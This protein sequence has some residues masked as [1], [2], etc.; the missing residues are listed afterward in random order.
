[1]FTVTTRARSLYHVHFVWHNTSPDPARDGAG[2]PSITC[3]ASPYIW[4]S[5]GEG[6]AA[7]GLATP[8]WPPGVRLT[9]LLVWCAGRR[10]Q[11]FV[12]Q[13]CRG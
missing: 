10:L 5:G 2:R 1:M 13:R 8:R 12:M 3:P 4:G 7:T 9:H 6:G 11:V